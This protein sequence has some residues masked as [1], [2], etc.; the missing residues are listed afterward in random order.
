MP[1]RVRHDMYMG[2]RTL[3]PFTL[4]LEHRSSAATLLSD[5]QDDK[6]SRREDAPPTTHP[7]G[8]AS[9]PRLLLPSF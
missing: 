3:L 5:P 9:R 6:G 7:V 2:G 1:Q 4:P 8:G